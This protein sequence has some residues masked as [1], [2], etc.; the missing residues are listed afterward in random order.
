MKLIGV[1]G[2][3]RAG[4][5][6]VGQIL[7]QEQNYIRLAFADPIKNMVASMLDMPLDKLE[8]I[9]DHCLDPL[10]GLTPRYLMQT[11][12]TNWGRDLIHK[13]IWVRLLREEILLSAELRPDKN[14][15]VTDVRF[16]EEVD[17]IRELGGHIWKVTRDNQ[18]I[19]LFAHESESYV[20]S[21]EVDIELL[22]TTGDTSLLSAQTI[23]YH[24]E[25]PH[26]KHLPS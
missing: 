26:L 17:M 2:F 7:V 22:N 1:T 15:V 16:P 5:D 25:T 19:N 20:P 9:K 3:A 14:I 21:I 24:F 11:L 4:K 23:M 18:N 8:E 12:G 13:D 10:D 6:T